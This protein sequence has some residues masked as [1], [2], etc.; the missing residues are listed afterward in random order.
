[1]KIFYMVL[2]SKTDQTRYQHTTYE[3]AEAEAKR[4]ASANPGTD[5]YVLAGIARV[6]R[7]DL[8]IERVKSDEIPF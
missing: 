7:N 6:V 3:A 1:M 2:N 8:L 4:L 5:F